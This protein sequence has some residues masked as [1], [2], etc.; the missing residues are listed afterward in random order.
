MWEAH[1]TRPSKNGPGDWIGRRNAL[2]ARRARSPP[3]TLGEKS[4][5]DCRPNVGGAFHRA[6]NGPGDWIGR[7]NALRCAKGSGVH[8]HIG[9]EGPADC[10]PNVGGAFHRADN[11]KEDSIGRS[12]PSTFRGQK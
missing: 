2:A 9:G 1:S 3:P 7:R 8:L 5:A 11:G 12:P 6:D 4:T 10:R